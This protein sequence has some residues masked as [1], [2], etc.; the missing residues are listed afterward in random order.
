MGNN[1]GKAKRN[2]S[3][4]KRAKAKDSGDFPAEITTSSDLEKFLTEIRDKMSDGTSAP[5]YSL[6]SL[7]YLLNL[8]NIYD[9]LDENNREIARD[10]WLRLKQSGFHVKAPPMLFDSSEQVGGS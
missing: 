7:R 3:N 5:I 4:S 2:S 9:I 8:P 6:S 10:I 1:T